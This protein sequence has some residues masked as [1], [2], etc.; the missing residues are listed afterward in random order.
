MLRVICDF[1]GKELRQPEDRHFVVKI[2]A[3]PA[4]DPAEPVAVTAW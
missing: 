2:E 3:Y 4:H 1:C